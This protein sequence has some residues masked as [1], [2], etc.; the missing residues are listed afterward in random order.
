MIRPIGI[1]ETFRRI[2]GKTLSWVLKN[3]IQ[4][5]AG[6]LQVCE[7]VKSGAEAAIHFIREQFE[8]D[9]AEAVIMADA[10]NAFNS[11]NRNVMIHNL[12]VICPEISTV[13]INM[14][15]KPI[16]LFVNGTEIVSMEGTTQGD[17]LAMPIFALSTLPILV[18]YP[19]YGL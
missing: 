14:Y 6:P 5:A 7:G 17:N 1:G 15:R 2:V 10:S 3:D 8:M 16:R 12:Q 18:V 13:T 11:L 19:S 4:E 9:A